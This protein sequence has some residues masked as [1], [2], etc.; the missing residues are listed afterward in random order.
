[1]TS[2]V[3]DFSLK[4]DNKV[5]AIH[6]CMG[7]DQDPNTLAKNIQ[8]AARGPEQ[9]AVMCWVEGYDRAKARTLGDTVKKV[10]DESTSDRIVMIH[11]YINTAHD[12]ERVGKNVQRAARGPRLDPVNIMIEIYDGDNG[13]KVWEVLQD[14][15]KKAAASPNVKAYTL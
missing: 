9:E 2:D 3:L 10:A 14:V 1:M 7:T 6:V 5:L 8:R 13:R 15:A 12:P 4:Y 11:L